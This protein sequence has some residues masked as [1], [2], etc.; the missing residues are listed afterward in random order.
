MAQQFAFQAIDK[1][2][3]T[4]QR[5]VI[6]RCMTLAQTIQ[7]KVPEKPYAAAIIDYAHLALQDHEGERA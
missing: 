6:P 5:Y 4:Q 3:L 7:Q 2:L 1:A